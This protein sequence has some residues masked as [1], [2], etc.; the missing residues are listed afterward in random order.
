MKRSR[1]DPHSP[2]DLHLIAAD[3]GLVAH[4][5]GDNSDPYKTLD[6]LMVVVEA[7]CPR[8]PEREFFTGKEK[9]RL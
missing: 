2:P 1:P 6:D 9:F 8:W 4:A 5:G 3:G 7:L